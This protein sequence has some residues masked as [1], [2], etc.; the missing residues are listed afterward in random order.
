[1]EPCLMGRRVSN[2]DGLRQLLIQ[3]DEDRRERWRRG[4]HHACWSN[5]NWGLP[6][7]DGDRALRAGEAVVLWSSELCDALHHAGLDWRPYARGGVN[8]GKRWLLD[9][10]DR[11]SEY[12]DEA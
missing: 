10:H 12:V 2:T 7:D 4:P 5:A 6:F 9:E 8:D 3:A 1:M 11:L